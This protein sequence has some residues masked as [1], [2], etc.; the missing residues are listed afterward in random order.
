MRVKEELGTWDVIGGDTT[1]GPDPSTTAMVGDWY[2]GTPSAHREVEVIAAYRQLQNEIDHLYAVIM[3]DV[4]RKVRI[5]FTGC[6]KP[7]ESDKEL[8]AA[9]RSEGTLEITS[10]ATAQGR[11]HPLF[12]CELGG[13]FDRFRAVHDFIG[14]AGCGLGFDLGDE[15]AAWMVQDRL[16]SCPARA[17][18]ATELYGVNA[19][20]SIAG[21]APE[22]R[23]L[24]L[25][26]A[27]LRA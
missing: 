24:L 3:R 1:L 7:Y 4:R 16:H 20:R 10:A 25:T 26:P 23:A 22:L 8:I 11:L 18:L 12:G 2:L 6:T 5:A 17:A 9:V 13:A 27:L 14:H 21:E 15:C 19:A